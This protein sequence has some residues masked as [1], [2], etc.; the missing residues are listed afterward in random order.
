MRVRTN[1]R[2]LRDNRKLS[3]RQLEKLTEIN[4]SLLS[5]MERGYHV[6]TDQEA[7][8]ICAALGATFDLLYPD[9][10][11]RRVLAE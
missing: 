6:P 1:M 9:P 7:E 3:L 2:L 8:K 11:L 4:F 10:E 5:Q